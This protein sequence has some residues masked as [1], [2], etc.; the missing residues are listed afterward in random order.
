[1]VSLFNNCYQIT[2]HICFLYIYNND[3]DDEIFTIYVPVSFVS[4]TGNLTLFSCQIFSTLNL[5][6]KRQ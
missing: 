5:Q 4:R 6:A 1:M 3:T 2:I